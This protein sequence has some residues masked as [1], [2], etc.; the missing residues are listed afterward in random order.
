M[1][2]KRMTVPTAPASTPSTLTL[3]NKND[4]PEVFHTADIG[5]MRSQK[6]HF[7]FVATELFAI[8]FAA[9]AQV[10]G[11]QIAPI[12]VNIF[13][14]RAGNVTVFGHTYPAED[15]T[16]SAARYALPA[17]LMAIAI[18]AYGLRFC[19]RYH[20]RWLGQRALAEA[21]KGLAWRYSM[22]GMHADLNATTPLTVDEAHQAFQTELGQIEQQGHDLRLA[23]PKPED[24]ELTQTM[25]RLRLASPA[26]Q[27]DA[28]MEDRLRTP[29]KTVIG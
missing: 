23:P 25:E 26:I 8:S 21:T 4:F 28:Y 16:T 11:Q 20:H 22:H 5:A 19:S 2:G 15:V 12:I 24:V 29:N 6:W 14:L 9:I 1:E 3:K 7:R 17:L 10:F 13:G 18:G 27:S